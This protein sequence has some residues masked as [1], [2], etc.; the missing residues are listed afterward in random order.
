MFKGLIAF[1]VVATALH[2]H[3]GSSTGGGDTRVG[4]TDSGGGRMVGIPATREKAFE[5]WRQLGILP[6]LCKLIIFA[7]GEGPS[8]C[9]GG[10]DDILAETPGGVETDIIFIDEPVHSYDKIIGRLRTVT[11]ED[12]CKALYAETGQFHPCMSELDGGNESIK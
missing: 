7:P 12:I 10:S 3:A 4:G 11:M 5:R 2:A 1:A 6:E 8:E 9:E